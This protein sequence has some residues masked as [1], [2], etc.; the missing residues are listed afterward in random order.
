[1]D[2]PR[3]GTELTSISIDGG[4]T[5]VYCDHCGFADIETSP[6]SAEPESE[7]WD[8]ALDRFHDAASDT[9]PEDTNGSIDADD[10]DDADENDTTQCADSES[11]S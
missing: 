4:S 2:C 11:D 7:T 9:N 10:N 5:A 8:D 6:V 1:M 3:C